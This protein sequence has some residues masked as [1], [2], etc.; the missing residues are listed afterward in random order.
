MP[1]KAV[2]RST[3]EVVNVNVQKNFVTEPYSS[4]SAQQWTPRPFAS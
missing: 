2:V 3:E 1:P 4:P